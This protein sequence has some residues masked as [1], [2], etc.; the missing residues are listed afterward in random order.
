M[1][2]SQALSNQ[3]AALQLLVQYGTEEEKAEGMER[4]RALALA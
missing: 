4:I 3:L 1:R 2:E